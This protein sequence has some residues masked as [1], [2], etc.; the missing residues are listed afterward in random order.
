MMTKKRWLAPFGLAVLVLS[1][2]AAQ[3]PSRDYPITPVPLTDVRLSGGF[4]GPRLDINRAV[5]IPAVFKQEEGTGRVKNFE[6]AG[7]TIE[8]AFCTRY[9][10]DDSDVYKGIEAASYSLLVDPDPAL[11]SYVDALIVKIAKAQE[12]DGYLY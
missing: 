12:Q 6:I 5:T 9:P 3:A 8:G 10:F 7:G 4:W 11:E 2:A 1:G